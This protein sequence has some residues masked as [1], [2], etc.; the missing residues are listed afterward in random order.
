MSTTLQ[1]MTD[2][3]NLTP[4]QLKTRIDQLPLS[5]FIEG[6]KALI[7]FYRSEMKD[8]K[9][10]RKDYCKGF[11]SIIKTAETILEK[12]ENLTSEDRIYFFGSMKEANAQK[13]AILQQLDGKESLL[14]WSAG[15]VGFGTFIGIA[16]AFIFGKKD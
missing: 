5:V 13:V 6:G 9:A 11:D 7:A 12:G 3:M 8:L 1:T 16:C 14:K 4:A 2:M 15:L 10:K